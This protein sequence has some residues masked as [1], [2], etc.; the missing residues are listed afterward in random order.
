MFACAL[1]FF[2]AE[3]RAEA[4][5]MVAQR[6]T[7]NLVGN[8]AFIVIS[9]PASAFVEADDNGDGKISAAEV[10]AHRSEL[11]V[12]IASK[13]SL[14]D[15]Q[16]PRTLE[17]L[18]LS[19]SP[20]DDAPSEPASQLVALGRF[21]LTSP[22]GMRFKLELFGKTE[23]EQTFQ[24]TVTRDATK[25][26]QVLI[27]TPKSTTH[28][29]FPSSWTV[30]SAYVLLGAKH[31]VT[32]LDHLLFLLIVLSAGMRLRALALVL[33]VFTLGHAVTLAVSTVGGASV[34]PGVV[35]PTIA[36]TLAGMAAFDLYAL[37]RPPP[38]LVRLSL[39]FAC[40]LVHGL[41][42][43]SALTGLGL[44][45]KYQ[46]PSLAGFNVGIEL[47]QLGVA[48]ATSL[49]AVRLAR[50]LGDEGMRKVRRTGLQVAFALGSLWFGQ[51]LIG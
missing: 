48:L 9:L 31:I 2:L 38:S 30:F 43:A 47:A 28:S 8:G 26:S 13:L 11:M 1:C 17:G 41:G 49:L 14:T 15:D 40:A 35:E 37:K 44:R 6:G 16:G 21:A 45:G 34:S 29:L 18:M 20:N 12:T 42:L 32:G 39:V 27:V 33:T 4:H 46:L 7:I 51:R 50:S 3:A 36:A 19:L 10:G 24:I 23:A 5:L 25:D 22:N